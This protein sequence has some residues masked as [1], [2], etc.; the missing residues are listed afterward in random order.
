M[1]DVTEPYDLVSH[2][3]PEPWCSL[4]VLREQ[5]TFTSVLLLPAAGR[6][7]SS[8]PDMDS[9]ISTQSGTAYT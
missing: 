5:G 6:V 7:G 3:E 1:E 2:A 9:I 8:F 4:P